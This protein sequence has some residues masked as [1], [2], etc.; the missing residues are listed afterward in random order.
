MKIRTIIPIFSLITAALLSFES[1][2]QVPAGLK[3]REQARA[4]SI[5]KIDQDLQQQES[6]DKYVIE[7]AKDANKETKAKAKQ[8]KRVERDAANASDETK[9]ALREE[10]K[11]QRARKQANQQ[12]RKASEARDKSDKN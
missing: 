12:A 4:D 2:G 6:K 5:R 7:N 1:Y 9:K 8:I 10:K 3:K 11:A